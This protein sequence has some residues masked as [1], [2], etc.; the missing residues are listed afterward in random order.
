MRSAVCRCVAST[1]RDGHDNGGANGTTAKGTSCARAGGPDS[2]LF[3]SARRSGET[4][5]LRCDGGPSE[6]AEARHSG[7]H[8]EGSRRGNA[9]SSSSFTLST[10]NLLMERTWG[11]HWACL[12]AP[13]HRRLICR[14]VLKIGSGQLHN[15]L[16]RH[17]S[18]RVTG[19]PFSRSA[20]GSPRVRTSSQA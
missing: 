8:C 4:T 14:S 6:M 1:L 12:R 5:C 3:S 15:Q 10:R 20:S 18:T 17:R 7:V 11:S 19:A 9:C 13:G 16:H 2:C